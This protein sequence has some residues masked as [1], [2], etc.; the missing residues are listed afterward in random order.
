MIVAWAPVDG[1]LLALFAAFV[2][3]LARLFLG[4]TFADR[5]LA[6]ELLGTIT[7][8]ALVT[9]AVANGAK[10]LID[11]ATLLAMLSFLAAVG[12]A[13]YFSRRPQP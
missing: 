1:V 10:S 7:I 5:I 4:P 6:M 12:F 8:A 2:A 13:I 9:L 11:V 3:A